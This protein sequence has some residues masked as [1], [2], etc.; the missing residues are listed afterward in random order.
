MQAIDIHVSNI[1][2]VRVCNASNVFGAHVKVIL[3]TKENAFN[4]NTRKIIQ[5]EM[6]M[7]KSLPIHIA[8]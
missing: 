3:I 8:I 4:E 7:S 5:K 6:N 1:G 2:R